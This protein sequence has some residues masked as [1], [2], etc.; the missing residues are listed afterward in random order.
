MGHEVRPVQMARGGA[1]DDQESGVVAELL[2][3]VRE[4]VAVNAVQQG[5]GA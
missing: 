4:Q 3:G 5:V 1:F 2:P